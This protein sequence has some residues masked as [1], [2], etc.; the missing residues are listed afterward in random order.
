MLRGEKNRM[1][2]FKSIQ[3]VLL[4]VRRSGGF[5]QILMQMQIKLTKALA[6]AQE[7]QNHQCN[8]SPCENCMG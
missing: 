6:W 3:A 1:S 5:T 7:H 8:P 2:K 4:R